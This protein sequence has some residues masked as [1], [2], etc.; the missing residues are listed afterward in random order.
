MWV[1][2]LPRGGARG[3]VVTARGVLV[4]GG[5]AVLLVLLALRATTPGAHPALLGRAKAGEPAEAAAFLQDVSAPLADI[6]CA[7][8]L[9]PANTGG[10]VRGAQCATMKDA[11]CHRQCCEQARRLSKPT[12]RPRGAQPRGQKCRTVRHRRTH[13]SYRNAIVSTSFTP[14]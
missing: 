2:L 13:D 14:A 3:I 10:N 12:L 5:G 1:P 9:L 8:P 4:T 6:V 11:A 7:N